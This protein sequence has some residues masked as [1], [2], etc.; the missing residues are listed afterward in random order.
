MSN[1]YQTD[2]QKE[3][4]MKENG[5]FSN[6]G[7]ARMVTKFKK[8]NV[9]VKLYSDLS[10]YG[11]HQH[12]SI[13][14]GFI[15]TLENTPGQ[16]YD[17]ISSSHFF[18]ERKANK[19]G[20]NFSPAVVEVLGR[21]GLY[22][23][24]TFVEKNQKQILKYGDIIKL[25]RSHALFQFLDDREF[26]TINIPR[27]ILDKYHVD[28]YIGHGGQSSVRLVHHIRTSGKFAMKMMIK[29][30]FPNESDHSYEKRNQHMDQEL[31]FLRN[32]HHPNIIKFIEHRET[33]REMFIFTEL[34]ED[35]NLLDYMKKFPLQCLPQ[36]EAKYCLYQIA[37]GVQHLHDLNIAHRDLKA[38]NIFVVKAP[39]RP[40]NDVIMKIGDF[41]YAKSAEFLSTQVGTP[42]FFPPEIQENKPYT[43]S[44]DIWTLGCLFFA[45]LSGKFPFHEA[46]G[47]SVKHQIEN[48]DLRF[49]LHVQWETVRNSKHKDF[50]LNDSIFNKNFHR[51]LQKL[52]T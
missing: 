13:P 32:L 46:Y 28:S 27:S 22:I 3:K 12:P 24:E 7:W 18:I 37:K 45:C 52:S 34:A 2:S 17:V 25:T 20:V 42:C 36:H 26:E 49:D 21:N 8:K 51:S 23:N 33:P 38:E 16:L 40:V 31:R 35:G 50:L 5:G 14:E 44:A 41:G 29:Y 15:F 9:T 10:F 6:L 43:I 1:H 30:R 19:S 11:K 47:S 48:A 39:N 4:L